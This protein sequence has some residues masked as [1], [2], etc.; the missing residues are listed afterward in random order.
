MLGGFA[1]DNESNNTLWAS[2]TPTQ[3]SRV[4]VALAWNDSLERES[5]QRPAVWLSVSAAL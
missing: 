2:L 3:S 5:P 4:L 1:C